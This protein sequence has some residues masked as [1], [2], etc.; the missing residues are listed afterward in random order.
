MNKNLNNLIN[1]IAT[2]YGWLNSYH[3]GKPIDN[4]MNPLPWYT[5]PAIEYLNCFDLQKLRI[6]EYG[7]G[8]ST[9]YFASRSLQVISI[10]DNE[11]WH[12]DIQQKL[13]E[14]GISGRA[15]VINKTDEY[16]YVTSLSAYRPDV[17]CIDGSFRKKVSEF[18]SLFACQKTHNVKMIIFDNSDW[19]PKTVEKLRLATKFFRT[20]FSGFG[21]INDYT[22][23]TS[24]LVNPATVEILYPSSPP[25]PIA[26]IG[27]PGPT[28]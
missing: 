11:K 23:T 20:D 19:Y 15:K 16:D 9:L 24:F 10:E 6:F 8:F 13:L 17:V 1:N 21:P 5:Y 18:V 25:R 2:K 12:Y 22:W 26:S 14:L 4:Q 28:D 3:S 27:D 7:C